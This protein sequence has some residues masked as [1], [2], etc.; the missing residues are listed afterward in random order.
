MSQITIESIS[1]TIQYKFTV[2]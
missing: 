1:L 2:H